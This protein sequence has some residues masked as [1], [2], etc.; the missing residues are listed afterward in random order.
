MQGQGEDEGISPRTAAA[1]TLALRGRGARAKEWACTGLAPA[2]A[3]RRPLD[4]Q[5]VDGSLTI[6]PS[7]VQRDMNSCFVI[8]RRT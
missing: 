5:R 4:R 8:L 2:I 1:L 7:R 3:L 6:T